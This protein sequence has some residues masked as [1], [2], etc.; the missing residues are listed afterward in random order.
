MSSIPLQSPLA[1]F[2][3]R[4]LVGLLASS[5]ATFAVVLHAGWVFFLMGALLIPQEP[6]TPSLMQWLGHA[7]L[8]GLEWIGAVERNGA[9][10]H[11]DA[12]TVARAMATLTPVIYLLQLGIAH[13]RRG[14]PAWSM[15]RK[16]LLSLTVAL[17][18][19]GTAL[20]LLPDGAFGALWFLGLVLAVLAGVATFWALLVRRV[21]DA[22]LRELGMAQ[23]AG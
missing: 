23:P 4:H 18:G 3:T 2:A 8:R 16:A 20:A 7:L 21:G 22:V 14:R 11:G 9:H 10:G 19:Y 5:Q 15:A 1:Q 13:L 17:L 6:G 12:G